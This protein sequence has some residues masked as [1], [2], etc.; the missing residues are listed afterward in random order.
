M[1]SFYMYEENHNWFTF[2]ECTVQP[3]IRGPMNEAIIPL[4]ITLYIHLSGVQIIDIGQFIYASKQV[5]LTS[6]FLYNLSDHLTACISD[7]I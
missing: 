6:L 1:S 5:F 7:H 3:Q 2:W 4:Y